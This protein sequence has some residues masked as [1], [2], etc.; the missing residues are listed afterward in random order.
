M[1]PAEQAFWDTVF[2]KAFEYGLRAPGQ[3]PQGW[4]VKTACE[5]ADAAL[6]ERRKRVAQ[7]P[8]S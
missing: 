8:A 3:A 5:M 2:L 1:D 4:I 6:E 7:L